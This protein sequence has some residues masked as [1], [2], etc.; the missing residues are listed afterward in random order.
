MGL[1][2]L[3]HKPKEYF[4]K[5]KK[6]RIFVFKIRPKYSIGSNYSSESCSPAELSFASF[7]KTKLNNV[8]QINK[9]IY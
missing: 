6:G 7:D 9:L 8:N 3:R 2:F 5:R 1:G 4:V